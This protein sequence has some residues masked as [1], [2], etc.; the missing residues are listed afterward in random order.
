MTVDEVTAADGTAMNDP[1]ALDKVVTKATR[2]P[3]DAEDRR[4]IN[5]LAER[6]RN[7]PAYAEAERERE[8]RIREDDTLDPRL[9]ELYLDNTILNTEE[10]RQLADVSKQRVWNWRAPAM[11]ERREK[12]HPRMIPDPDVTLMVVGGVDVPGHKRGKMWE[13]LIADTNRFRWDPVSGKPYKNPN[14][15]RQGAPRKHS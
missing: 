12:P 14:P 1:H 13:W 7:D 6:M 11:G 4:R 2:E 3:L 9:K 10:V 5:L 15:P 8:R